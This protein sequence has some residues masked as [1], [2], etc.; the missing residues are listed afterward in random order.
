MQLPD[1]A[2]LA[3]ASA[4]LQQI[5]DAPADEQGLHIDASELK[6]FDTS[7]VAVL[8]AARR[9]AEERSVPFRIVNPP[10]KL[11]EL[12]ELY[13]VDGLLSLSSTESG[14]ARPVAT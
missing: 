8:L 2:T 9:L 1:T 11:A 4:L 3:Q 13:G 14:P 5:E 7:L 12:A 10:P 6:L